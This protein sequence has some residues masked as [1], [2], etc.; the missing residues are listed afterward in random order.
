M[1]I[2][3]FEV[4]HTLDFIVCLLRKI[5]IGA[6]KKSNNV[7]NNTPIKTFKIQQYLFSVFVVLMSEIHS[8]ITFYPTIKIK[9]IS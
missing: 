8:Y 1:L 5:R 6:A 4:V 9:F 7:K 3:Y 2:N